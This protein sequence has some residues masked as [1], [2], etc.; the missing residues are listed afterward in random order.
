[1]FAFFAGSLA[2][3]LHP[4]WW[5][6]M[7]A[8]LWSQVFRR[9]RSR[10]AANFADDHGIPDTGL[11]PAALLCLSVTSNRW[12]AFAQIHLSVKVVKLP[13]AVLK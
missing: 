9:F 1:M 8:V 4:L 12:I 7:V 2:A 13:Q 6:L 10:P 5:R 3:F 11:P